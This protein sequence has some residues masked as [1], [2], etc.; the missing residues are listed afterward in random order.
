[1]EKFGYGTMVTQVSATAPGMVALQSSGE[2]MSNTH[3]DS[4]SHAST[5]RLF[6]TLID[7]SVNS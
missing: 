1:M 2:S 4:T 6:V 7:T 5:Y 3:M